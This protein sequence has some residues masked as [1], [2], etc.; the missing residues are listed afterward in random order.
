MIFMSENVSN[1]V[2]QKMN[3]QGLHAAPLVSIPTLPYILQT[4]LVV[5][6]DFEPTMANAAVKI[7]LSFTDESGNSV[8]AVEGC[9]TTPTMVDNT[10]RM[11]MIIPIKCLIENYGHLLV[12]VTI[13][14]AITYSEMWAVK[15]DDG[16]Y[17]KPTGLTN[18]SGLLG[19]SSGITVDLPRF[20]G[21]ASSSLTIIDQYI[22]ATALST[23][24]AHVGADVKI[25]VLTR[26]KEKLSYDA[27]INAMRTNHPELC[28]GFSRTFH[29]RF[30]ILNEREVYVFGYS[31]KDLNSPRVS[32]FTKLFSMEESNDAINAFEVDWASCS[33][34]LSSRIFPSIV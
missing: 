27:A 12:H 26:D 2:F 14:N 18:Q 11:C 16:P 5:I 20:L 33:K 28:V 30:V 4:N 23:L 13:G 17:Y 29:D 25:R 32:Y 1:G 31:L 34:V 24:I 21:M 7:T 15:P 9:E 19:T 8:R 6:A 10:L 22:P 3:L